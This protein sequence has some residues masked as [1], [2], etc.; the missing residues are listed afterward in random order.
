M[1]R[2]LINEGISYARTQREEISSILNY[3]DRDINALFKTLDKLS[4]TN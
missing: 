4:K 3:N 2:Y 1:I